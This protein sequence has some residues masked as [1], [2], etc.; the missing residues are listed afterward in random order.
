VSDRMPCTCS[1]R[2]AKIS[3][4]TARTF[5]WFAAILDQLLSRVMQASVVFLVCL[6]GLVLGNVAGD[7]FEPHPLIIHVSEVEKLDEA[8]AN[9]MYVHESSF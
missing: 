8:F 7:V 2:Q 9:T 3:Q 4:E 1:R 5:S 6:V